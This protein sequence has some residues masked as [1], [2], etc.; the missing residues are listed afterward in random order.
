VFSSLSA[1]AS[2]LSAMFSF[3][4][5]LLHLYQRCSLFISDIHFAIIDYPN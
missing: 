1:I 5:R 4:Q 3:Y 2:L